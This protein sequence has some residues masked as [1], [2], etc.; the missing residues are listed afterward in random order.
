[1]CELPS[2]RHARPIG[3]GTRLDPAG[4][5]Q[6]CVASPSYNRSATPDPLLWPTLRGCIARQRT[7]R[8][9]PLPAAGPPLEG[10]ATWPDN[11]RK[12]IDVVSGAQVAAGPHEPHYQGAPT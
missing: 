2:P 12:R 5:L 9:L 10:I 1:A 11:K 4:D 3:H 7:P 6:Q 8:Q